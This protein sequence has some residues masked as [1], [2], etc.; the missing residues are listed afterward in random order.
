[1]PL[2][3]KDGMRVEMAPVVAKVMACEEVVKMNRL[4]NNLPASVGSFSAKI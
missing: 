2:A 4:W 3:G 1:M